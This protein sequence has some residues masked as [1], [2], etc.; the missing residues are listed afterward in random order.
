M[1]SCG[2]AFAG[3][4]R[5]C[6]RRPGAAASAQAARAY[7]AT[8]HMSSWA[9]HR[10]DVVID[11]PMKPP[12]A[13]QTCNR[14]TPDLAVLQKVLQQLLA[15]HVHG[16]A[17]LCQPAAEYEQQLRDLTQG[18][19]TAFHEAHERASCAPSP[20]VCC[21]AC[22]CVFAHLVWTARG[23]AAAVQCL[24]GAIC[25]ST[26][27][28]PPAA[29]FAR[30][31][32]HPPACHKHGINLAFCKLSMRRMHASQPSC[33]QTRPARDIRRGDP[34]RDRPLPQPVLGA[35]R[36]GGRAAPRAAP[37]AR[38]DAAQHGLL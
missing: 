31:A 37:A 25:D 18:A 30:Q 32:L 35:P 16:N 19:S 8:L 7:A 23:A 28:V 17:K 20:F 10:A 2:C 33:A 27:T 13:P 4:F 34:E 3:Y 38:A 22:A 9:L 1:R 36:G 29:A 21:C 15:V 14:D 11:A 24:C 5:H 26:C 12:C 6:A